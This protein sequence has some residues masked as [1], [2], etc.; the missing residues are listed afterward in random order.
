MK[1][2]FKQGLQPTFIIQ[3]SLI[4]WGFFLMQISLEVLGCFSGLPCSA[5]SS[6]HVIVAS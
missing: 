1:R 4:T 3:P 6:F 5:D 2:S